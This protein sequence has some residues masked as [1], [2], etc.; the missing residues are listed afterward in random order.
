MEGARLD[1]SCVLFV[2]QN[3]YACDVRELLLF[4]CV[5]RSAAGSFAPVALGAAALG[6]RDADDWAY[7]LVAIKV[8]TRFGTPGHAGTTA[9]IGIGLEDND[10]DVRKVA[11]SALA[12]LVAKGDCAAIAAATARLEHESRRVRRGATHVLAKISTKLDADTV[13]AMAAR[14]EDR[15][16]TVRGAASGAFASF[17]ARGDGAATAAAAALLE[18]DRWEVRVTAQ[19]VFARASK[20]CNPDVAAAIAAHVGDGGVASTSAPTTVSRPPK[21]RSRVRR[22]LRLGAGQVWSARMACPSQAPTQFALTATRGKSSLPRPKPL[23]SSPASPQRRYVLR[24]T[25]PMSPRPQSTLLP[26][27]PQAAASSQCHLPQVSG[28]RSARPGLHSHR[29]DGPRACGRRSPDGFKA[30]A[31][32]SWACLS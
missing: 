15:D 23:L 26:P 1:I 28:Q 18:H 9:A 20:C 13:A 8:L 17:I 32:Q 27:S 2:V 22:A 12:S 16:S 6:L 19:D 31:T 24:S 29:S 3:F 4:R 21:L 5:S 10:A 7:R 30:T 25:T 11:T 14:L